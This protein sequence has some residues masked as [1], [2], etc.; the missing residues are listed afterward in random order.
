MAVR[1]ENLVLPSQDVDLDGLYLIPEFGKRC[2]PLA[3]LTCEEIHPGAEAP[4]GSACCMKCNK[5]GRDDHPKLQRDPRTDPKPEPKPPTSAE[6][7][8][9]RKQKR[10]ILQWIKAQERKPGGAKAGPSTRAAAQAVA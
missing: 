8:L 2:T 6:P 4:E 5:S 3:L 9:T 1:W 7:K 10:K